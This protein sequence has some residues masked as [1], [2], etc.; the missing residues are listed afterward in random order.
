VA[1]EAHLDHEGKPGGDANVH[2]S[3][4]AVHKV[5]VEAR[6]CGERTPGEVSPRRRPA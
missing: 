2:Q 1:V 3:E 5:E 6:T 4:L